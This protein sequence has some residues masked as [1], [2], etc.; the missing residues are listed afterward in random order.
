MECAT[1]PH[2][3]DNLPSA[4]RNAA[5]FLDSLSV[6][7][8]LGTIVRQDLIARWTK[9]GDGHFLQGELNIK[10][11]AFVEATEAWLCALTAFE[12]A[13]RL[14]DEGDQQSEA[15]SAK[16]E[17]SV[18]RF[19]Q[20]LPQKVE[21]TKVACCDLAELA[22][23]YLPAG[24]PELP[25][26]AIICI[27][28]EQETGA[29]LLGR[30][31]PVIFGRGVSVLV[32]SYVDIANH[33]LG[34]SEALLSWCL[35]YLSVRP[36]VDRTRIGVYGEGL[37]AALATEFAASDHR[38]AA[39]VC[40]GGLW[41]WA[42]IVASVDWMTRVADATADDDEI[43]ARRLH[44]VRRVRCPVLVV[45]G[46]RGIVSVSEAIKLQTSCM[47][48]RIDLD[49]TLPRAI[50]GPG[51]ANENFVSTDDYIFEWLENKL[52]NGSPRCQKKITSC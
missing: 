27:S 42:R 6:E 17:V 29:T 34:Q 24:S 4:R 9:I 7:E 10:K 41:N 49:L 51:G 13:R 8:T 33:S 5:T 22:A 40:D 26:P 43:S 1:R 23:Y 32:I 16:V 36:E 39:A 44:W 45:A 50:R 20:S 38:V 12:V 14:V 3:R 11:G 28:M 48:E 35:D 52:A 31:L 46:G 2:M 47:A 37:S 21:R 25:A 19:E 18:Q 15:L 30:L